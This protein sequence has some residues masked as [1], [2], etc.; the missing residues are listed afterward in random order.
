MINNLDKITNYVDLTADLEENLI[1][2]PEIDSFELDLDNVLEHEKELFGFYL[3][4]HKTEKYKLQY[5]SIIDVSDIKNYL[6]KIG[7]GIDFI[8][9]LKENIDKSTKALP[10][11]IFF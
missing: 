6:N 11:S 10:A 5:K 2:K 4:S 3:T 9:L 8:C 1:E 7:I